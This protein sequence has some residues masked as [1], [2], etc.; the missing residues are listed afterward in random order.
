MM[1]FGGETTILFVP[2][3]RDHVED[4]WQTHAARAIPGAATV[5]PLAAG[6]LSRAGQVAALD[7]TLRAIPGE[8]VIVAHSAGCLTTVHWALAPTR[9]IR[10]ALLVTPADIENPLPTGYPEPTALKE[11]GWLP[12]PRK[13]LPFPAIVVAS[14]NDPLATFD[15]VASFADAWR[16]ALYDGGEVGH[17]N[18]AAGYGPWPKV[19]DL[20]DELAEHARSTAL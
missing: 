6:R 16:A 15:R 17:L 20:L 14:R 13:A 5:A 9:T 8:V 19:A 10:A 2:G 12:I 4:H 11:G 1:A 18:P 7:A 3:L